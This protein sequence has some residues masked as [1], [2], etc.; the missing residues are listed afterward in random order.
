MKECS[1]RYNIAAFEDGLIEPCTK[2]YGYIPEAGGVQGRESQIESPEKCA[3]PPALWLWPSETPV[4]LLTY[5]TV[6]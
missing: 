2:E 3:A 5:R 6:I 4:E 1:E